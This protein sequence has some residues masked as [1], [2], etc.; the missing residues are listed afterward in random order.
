MKQNHNDERDKI[1]RTKR[2]LRKIQIFETIHEEHRD[3]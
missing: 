2:T 1:G 3:D